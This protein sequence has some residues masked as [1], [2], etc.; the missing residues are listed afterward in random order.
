[1]VLEK[2]VEEC[3]N[4]HYPHRLMQH[5]EKSLVTQAIELLGGESRFESF[6]NE[7]LQDIRGRW[8]DLQ[9]FVADGMYGHDPDSPN[10]EIHPILCITIGTVRRLLSAKTHTLEPDESRKIAEAIVKVKKWD[11]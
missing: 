2:S 7:V 11:E 10:K 5:S 9:V 1:M 8:T 3:K 6:S 4:L